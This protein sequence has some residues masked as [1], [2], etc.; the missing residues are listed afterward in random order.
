MNEQNLK[1]GNPDTMFSG[2]L[3][4]EAQ[5]KSVEERKKNI[6]LSKWLD[7][8]N[9]DGVPYGDCVRLEMLKIALGKCWDAETS[10]LTQRQKATL[11][12]ER[13]KI[14]LKAIEDILTGTGELKPEQTININ[15]PR[16]DAKDLLEKLKDGERL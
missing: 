12:I 8:N 14:Q 5:K 15:T 7:K 9:S 3:A 16:K 1:K 13:K 10:E 6:V 2:R 4:V 11:E